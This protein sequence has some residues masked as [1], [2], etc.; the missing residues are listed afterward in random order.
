MAFSQENLLINV[1]HKKTIKMQHNCNTFVIPLTN[2]W[3]YWL[4]TDIF[5]FALEIKQR[6]KE[7][8]IWH[9]SKQLDTKIWHNIYIKYAFFQ[10]T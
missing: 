1:Q 2:A 6:Q 4:Q 9:F 10:T 7:D 8:K 3:S 5:F